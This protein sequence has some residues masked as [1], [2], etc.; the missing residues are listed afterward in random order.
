[1]SFSWAEYYTLAEDLIHSSGLSA[2]DEAKYRTAISRAYYA[3]LG[4]ARKYLI[5]E[6]YPVPETAESHYTVKRDFIQ[7]SKNLKDR[8]YAV[9]GQKLGI[10]R[11]ERAKADYDDIVIRVKEIAEGAIEDSKYIIEFLSL[12]GIK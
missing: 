6:G 1:M 3:A 2:S 12:L 10:L 8:R 4:L 7:V 5:N 9:V 11:D